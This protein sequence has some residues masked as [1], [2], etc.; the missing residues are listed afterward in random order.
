MTDNRLWRH[1]TTNIGIL[2]AEDALN[3]GCSGVMLRG[4]GIKWDL[5]KAA[6]YDA[7]DLVRSKISSRLKFE[8]F[9][10]LASFIF[11]PIVIA[12]FK[13][14]PFLHYQVDQLCHGFFK[15]VGA[16]VRCVNFRNVSVK[17]W[18]TLIKSHFKLKQIQML[19]YSLTPAVVNLNFIHYLGRFWRS[20]WTQWWH[21]RSLPNPY[22]RNEAVNQVK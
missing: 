13:P 5:R 9:S 16:T 19:P 12:G 1:R 22:A 15:I 21:L 10:A 3:W 17:I 8:P 2:S 20:R 18:I 6:P 7:Y 4:S 11:Y 14:E